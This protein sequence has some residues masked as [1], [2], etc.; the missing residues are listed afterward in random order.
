MKYKLIGYDIVDFTDRK[1]GN[2]IQGFHLYFPETIHDGH[3]PG[4][5]KGVRILMKKGKP[6]FIKN[7]IAEKINLCPALIGEELDLEWDMNGYLVDLAP[8]TK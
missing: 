5:G 6:I 8:L 2:R 7:D 3:E 4:Q 1:S